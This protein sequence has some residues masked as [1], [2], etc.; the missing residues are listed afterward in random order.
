MRGSFG[1]TTFHDSE[2]IKIAPQS[3]D[4]NPDGDHSVFKSGLHASRKD[5]KH[6]LQTRF[7][8]FSRMPWSSQACS[9]IVTIIWR[10]A[11][12]VLSDRR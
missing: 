11:L 3:A 2:V 8:S 4:T 7:L 6:M 1:I 10:H 5:H 9:A 12:E